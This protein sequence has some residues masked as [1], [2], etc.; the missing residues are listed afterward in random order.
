M[1]SKSCTR[2]GIIL[3]LACCIIFCSWTLAAQVAA[4]SPADEGQTPLAATPPMG[5]NS[6][7]SYAETVSESDTKANAAW[8][9]EHLKS[10]GWEYIVVDE[11]WYVTNHAAETNGGA[12]EFSLDAYGRYVPAVNSIPSAENGAGFKP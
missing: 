8:M 10:Y 12:P 5:W 6:W 7:D 3:L 2:R 1:H 4:N 9:A 11:G